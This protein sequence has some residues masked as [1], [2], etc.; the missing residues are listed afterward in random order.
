[1]QLQAK[2]NHY[3][4]RPLIHHQTDPPQFPL[5]ILIVGPLQKKVKYMI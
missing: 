1:M 2:L 4:F 3:F 5:V